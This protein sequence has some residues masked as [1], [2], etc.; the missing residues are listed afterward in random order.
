MPAGLQIERRKLNE[1]IEDAFIT[2]AKFA[3]NSEMKI[4]S[5]KGNVFPDFLDF[6]SNFNYLV[7]L[8][9]RLRELKSEDDTGKLDKLKLDIRKW[10]D[11]SVCADGDVAMHTKEGLRLFDDYYSELMHS[12]II[13]LPTKK[14]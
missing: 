12:G 9:M 7:R 6:Y 5:G 2:A 10:L 3:A 14:G 4:A 1:E 13:S 8:T 11:T